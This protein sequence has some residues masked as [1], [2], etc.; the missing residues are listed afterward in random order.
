M[1]PKSFVVAIIPARSGS[2]SLPKKNLR[3]LAGKPLVAWTI[4]AAL[5]SELIDRVIVSTDSE[6]IA[7]LSRE[8]G[9]DVPFLRP[10]ELA[11]DYTPMLPVLQHAVRYLEEKEGYG[12][13]VIVTLQPTSPLRDE[14]DI[15]EA[16]RMFLKGNVDSLVSVCAVRH[17]PYKMVRVVEG[18]T[19]PIIAAGREH[20]RRQD[21]PKVYRHNGAIYVTKRAILMRENRI[22]GENTL[23]YIM[24]EEK[25][26]D[27]DSALDLKLAECYLEMKK[28]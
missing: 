3:A 27:I 14:G 9:A 19:K 1:D 6:E 23:A 18:K 2:K 21:L 10:D 20:E 12:V 13:D 15:D 11:T 5:R 28:K 26:I 7:K 25:S 8:Y 22:L 24:P 4:E 16:L 17:H